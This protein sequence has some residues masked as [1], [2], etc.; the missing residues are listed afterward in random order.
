MERD[1]WVDQGVAPCNMSTIAIYEEVCWQQ[2]WPAMRP[3][4]MAVSSDDKETVEL[5]DKSF[6]YFFA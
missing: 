5:L 2:Y 1:R 4:S 6:I 3:R